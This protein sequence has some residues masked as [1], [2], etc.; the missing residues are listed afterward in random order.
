M[1][2]KTK[3]ELI[4]STIAIAIVACA[5]FAVTIAIAWASYNELSSLSPNTINAICADG[6]C[7]P[8]S[9]GL[10]PPTWAQALVIFLGVVTAAIILFVLMFWYL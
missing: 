7:C 5:V 10:T 9:C 1:N 4:A 8:P 2:Q 6:G 3:D